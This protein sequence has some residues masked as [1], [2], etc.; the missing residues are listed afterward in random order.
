M[1]L[2]NRISGRVIRAVALGSVVG[3]LAFCGPA[4][5]HAGWHV[6][7][8]S[9]WRFNV[10]KDSTPGDNNGIY[11]NGSQYDSSDPSDNK[12]DPSSV[13]EPGT[14]ALTAAGM[15]L[16]IGADQRRRRRATGK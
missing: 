6:H 2:R 1:T 15:I 4:F 7:D 16:L 9:Q 14:L 11:N 8:G 3:A 13:P 5:A 12:K 10:K